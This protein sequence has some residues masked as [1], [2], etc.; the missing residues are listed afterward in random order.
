[1]RLMPMRLL[2]I[3]AL[4]I[5][6]FSGC[7]KNN[8]RPSWLKVNKWILQS[9]P[10]LS[11]ELGELT[12]NFKEAWVYVNDE[13]IGVFQVP[14]TIPILKKGPVNIKLY[15]TI[16]NNGISASKKIYPFVKEFNFSGTLVQDDTLE[17]TPTTMY[18]DGLTI[19]KED[20]EDINIKIENDPNTSMTTLGISNENTQ[21]FNGVNYGKVTLNSTDSMWVAYTQAINL[22]K[23]REVYL[24]IDYLTTNNVTTGLIFVS[25]QGVQNNIYI[26]LN[27]QEEGATNWKK[28]YIDLRELVGAAPANSEF[29]PSFFAMIDPGKTQTTIRLDN[30]KVIYL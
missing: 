30:I 10:A 29:R 19:W 22:P 12:E 15:P 1:M 25:P 9:N 28:I 5:T 17:I 3:F 24:E 16:R 7:V 23:G 6:V 13:V 21:P 8:E 2:F 27:A 11:G 26:R 20:F 18:K 14:F 4:L